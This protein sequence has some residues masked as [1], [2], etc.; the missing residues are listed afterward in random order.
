MNPPPLKAQCNDSIA[1]GMDQAHY[2]FRAAPDAPRIA[3]PNGAPIA[4]FALLHLETW[5]ITPPPGSHKDPRFTG[6]FPTFFPDLRAWSQREYGNRVGIFRVLSVLDRCNIVPAVALSADSAR[7]HP[8]LVA[9]LKSRGAEFLAHG[10]HATR[11]ITSRMT[12]AEERAHIIDSRDAVAEATGTVPRGW[13]GQDFSESTRTPSL[14]ASLGF[15]HVLD[16]PNDDRPYLLGPY[17]DGRTLVSLPPQPEWDDV[18]MMWLKRM[19]P[20]RWADSAADA[21]AFLHREGAR[22]ATLFQL[23]L[24]PW[25]AGQAHRIRYLAEALSRITALPNTWHA[26]PSAIAASYRARHGESPAPR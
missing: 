7:R 23:G 24:H 18:T 13:V 25:V 11:M 1:P 22:N 26:T 20:A 10:T 2:T 4:F 3:W 8:E 16:W 12:E 6:E 21:F 15:D 9:E 14:L 17:A 19:A 5:E